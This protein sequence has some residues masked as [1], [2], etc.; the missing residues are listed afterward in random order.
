MWRPFTITTAGDCTLLVLADLS[1]GKD[2][3]RC[4]AGSLE[5]KDSGMGQSNDHVLALRGKQCV[6]TVRIAFPAE[7]LNRCGMAV[8]VSQRA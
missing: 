3:R 5:C 7:Q 8:L 6:Q 4:H 1:K 2:V